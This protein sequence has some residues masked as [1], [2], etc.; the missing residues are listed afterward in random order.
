VLKKIH[1]E[2]HDP[3]SALVADLASLICPNQSR[4]LMFA[5]TNLSEPLARKAA[6]LGLCSLSLLV[7]FSQWYEDLST[8][9]TKIFVVR[10]GDTA[11]YLAIRYYGYFNDSLFAALKQAN[12]HLADLNLIHAGDTLFFP[13]RQAP[14]PAPELLRTQAANAVVT[15]AEGAVRYRRGANAAFEPAAANLILHTDDEIE[16]G[17][18]GRAE[19]VL[20]NRSVMRLAA[21]SRLKILALQRTA[22][23]RNTESS[24]QAGFALNLGSLWARITHFLDQPPKVEV[25]LPTAIAGVQGTVYRAVVAADS[26]TSVRVYEGSVR[27]RA[28][29]PAGGP[30]RI[31]P[32]QQIPGPRQITVEQWIKMVRAHQELVIAKDGKPGE[33][34]PFTDQGNDLAWV[35]WNQA[36]DRDLE[37]GR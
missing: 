6:G 26:A 32:P 18:D 1:P 4:M 23:A 19:L 17:K 33:P 10:K 21:N 22:T 7:F 25:K 3:G 29:P 8:G 13:T 2:W 11:S 36:R 34:R 16:T 35:R 31:G 28:N 9:S 20:D 30:Q 5:R 12:G 37:P 27:V 15:L 14:S 24:Y